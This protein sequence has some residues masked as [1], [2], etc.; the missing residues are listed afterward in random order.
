M[1]S[2]ILLTALSRGVYDRHQ[3]VPIAGADVIVNTDADNQYNADDI[4]LLTAALLEK[5]PMV[6]GQTNIEIPHFSGEKAFQLGS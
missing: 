2:S 3:C 4:P 6:I 1:S 5:M